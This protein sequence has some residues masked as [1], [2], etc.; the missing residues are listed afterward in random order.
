L[1]QTSQWSWISAYLVL[2]LSIQTVAG[3]IFVD[4]IFSSQRESTYV[5]NTHPEAIFL[6]L[7]Q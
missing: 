7:P 2:G 3:A 1:W 4:G 6:Q 5:G